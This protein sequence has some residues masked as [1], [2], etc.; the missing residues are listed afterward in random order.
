MANG[1][2]G[3]LCKIYTGTFDSK[4]DI[5]G[6]GDATLTHQG[7]P[8]ELNN[9]STGGW[10]VNL[11]D[12]IS[13]KALDI[14]VEFTASDDDSVE[15]LVLAANSGAVGTYV[16]DFIGYYYEGSFTPV[17]NTETAAK[18]TAVTLAVTFQSSD[19]ITRTVVA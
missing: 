9:K 15:A 11:D 3:G 10:R 7:A 13:T 17:L 2:N 14:A 6:Q 16:F 8:I 1:Y 19:E 12:S 4:Q 5:V 18:D